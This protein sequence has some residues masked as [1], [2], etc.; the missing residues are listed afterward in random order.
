MRIM[1]IILANVFVVIVS[2]LGVNEY[3]GLKRYN[4]FVVPFTDKMIGMGVI[5]AENRDRLLREDRVTHIVGVA[6]SLAVWVMLAFF[7]AGISAI[8]V[9]V[10]ASAGQMIV[11]KP[12]MTETAA[13]RGQY[14]NAHKNQMDA[15]KYHEYLQT[16]EG[17][18]KPEA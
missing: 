14:F 8:P 17:A 5:A 18:P 6:L 4:S 3:F 11:L 16:V 9:F 7:I 12:D 10:A 1:L 13:T 2:V 15:M